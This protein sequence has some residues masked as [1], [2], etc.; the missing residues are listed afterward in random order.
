MIRKLFAAMKRKPKYRYRSSVTGKMVS[1]AYARA[2][3]DITV[4]ERV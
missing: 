3:P 4:R 1:E 2:F